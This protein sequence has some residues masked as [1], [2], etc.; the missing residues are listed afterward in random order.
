MVLSVIAFVFIKPILPERLFPTAKT[1]MKNVVVD[2]LMLEALSDD[3][4][5]LINDEIKNDSLNGIGN[6]LNQYIFDETD[7]NGYQYLVPFFEKLFEIQKGK[8]GKVRIAYFG[9]SMND[10]DMIVKDFRAN[11][12]ERFGGEGVGFVNITSESASSRGTIKQLSS[13]KWKSYSFVNN[14]NIASNFGISGNVFFPIDTV[15]SNWLSFEASKTNRL[16]QL[17]NPIL[18]Y[19]KAS[20]SNA[21][22]AVINGNDTVFKK[23]NPVKVVNQLSLGNTAKKIKIEFLNAEKVPFYGVDF[24]GDSGVYVDNFSNRG[25]SGLPIINI[26]TDVI[27]AFNKDLNYDLIVLQYGTNV[28]GYGSKN[29]NWYQNRMKKVVEHLRSVLPNTPIL[30]VSIAD[31][32][33]KYDTQMQTDSAV[34]PLMKAQLN[35]AKE[36]QTAFVNLFQLMGGEGSMVKWVEEEPAKANKDYTHFNFRG[37]KFASDLIYNQIMQGYDA[38]VKR[39]SKSAE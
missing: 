39:K 17:I 35:Y 8:S 18:Y 15:S 1:T 14:K 12:Q 38:F 25:N 5:H 4:T 36:S 37:S 23:L 10:G 29:F 34:I 3:D 6:E 27:A 30:I 21:E 32:S 28:L 9:D 22:I 16:T 11:F 13:S 26:K 2:S 20:S 24:T 7:Y 19:G 33:T 31:K